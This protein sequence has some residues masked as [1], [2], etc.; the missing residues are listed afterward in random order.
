MTRRRRRRRL[1]PTRGSLR[2]VLNTSPLIVLSKLGLL[3]LALT[4]LFYEA[5]LPRGVMSELERK[6][7]AVYH[8]VKDL[9]RR[10]LLK[11]EEVSVSFPRLGVGESSAIL[12]ALNKGKVAVLDDKK[13]RRLA[14][15][16]GLEVIGSIAI[17]RELYEQGYIKMTIEELYIK[18]L[19]LGFYIK[20]DIYNK[21]FKNKN[22]K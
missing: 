12:V 2:V 10:G 5:Q 18:L 4:E 7:D 8:L 22:I 11:V 19:N 21:I 6:N 16:L 14:R 17:L 13:A 1:K 15:E 20:R 9:V 3:E